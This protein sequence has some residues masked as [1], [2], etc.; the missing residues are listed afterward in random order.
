MPRLSR[1]SRNARAGGWRGETFRFGLV[2]ISATLTHFVVAS[3]LISSG[4]VSLFVANAVGF[5]TAFAVSFFGHH[6]FSFRS[7]AAYASSFFRFCAVALSGFGVNNVVVG[8]TRRYLG[9]EAHLSLAAGIAAGAVTVFLLAKFWA[10]AS[11]GSS[12]S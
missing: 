8:V 1:L 7:E 10:F 5:V 3:L 2:G 6:H 4:F 9:A 12:P 11:A